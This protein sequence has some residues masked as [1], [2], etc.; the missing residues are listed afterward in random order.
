[1][2]V[3]V[4]HNFYQQHG[5]ED[6]VFSAETELLRRYGHEVYEYTE[7]NDRIN[8]MSTLAVAVNTIWSLSSKRKIIDIIDRV[9][10]DVVH[11]HNTFLLISPSA[12]YACKEKNVPV[13]QSLHNPR[14]LCP[15]ANLYR[16]GKVCED[17]VGKTL[18]WPGVLHG[19]YR[20]S[21]AQTALVSTMLT[22]HRILKTWDRMI[23]TYIVFTEFYRK[24]FIDGGIHSDKI[25]IKPHFV[26]PDPGWRNGEKGDYA[27]YIGRL[28]KEKGVQTLLKAW[29][30]TAD[31]PLK[32]RG[33]GN[34][35]SEVSDYISRNRLKSVEIV[36]RL[37]KEQLNKLIKKARFLVW[38]SEGYYE[39]FGLV[40]IEAFA[41]GVP[42]IASRTGTLAENVRDG[43]TGLHFTPGDAEDLS[44][45]INWAWNNP[46]KMARMG[47]NARKDYETHYTAERNYNILLD[48][49]ERA[50]SNKS[51][52][53]KGHLA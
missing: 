36:K 27:L 6:T 14:L 13:I 9:K 5:G 48:L 8:S 53:N 26:D 42:V 28:D 41:C 12:Y 4:A 47:R 40:A 34:L 50:I 49:Y 44:A 7:S 30:N 22:L 35:L 31:V 38:P 18:S 1:M 39:T 20:N 19:C 51:S 11:F 32:I 37:D 43:H 2:R 10:P 33:D 16:D 25:T 3:L 45:K 46:S 15:S 21:R 24:K 23:D 52:I 29:R 17:C